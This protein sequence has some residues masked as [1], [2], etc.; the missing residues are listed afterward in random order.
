MRGIDIG[1]KALGTNFARAPRPVPNATLE[2]RWAVTLFR[3][4]SPGDDHDIIV[5][6][7]YLKPA[8]TVAKATAAS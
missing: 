3:A 5:V 7:L 4:I 1:I 6:R 8:L 2:R